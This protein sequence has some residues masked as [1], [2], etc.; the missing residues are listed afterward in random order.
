MFDLK[1][2]ELCIREP[3]LIKVIDDFAYFGVMKTEEGYYKILEEEFI[4][5]KSRNIY[6]CLFE[7]D[8][9]RKYVTD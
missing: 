9:K 6:P 5:E 4:I 2:S 1:L 8:Y 3:T 7:I